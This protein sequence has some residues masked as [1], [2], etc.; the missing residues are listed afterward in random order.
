VRYGIYCICLIFV[1]S[2]GK[3]SIVDMCRWIIPT[4]DSEE[5]EEAAERARQMHVSACWVW[6]PVC[7]MK[8]TYS[9][10][11]K[12]RTWRG[13]FGHRREEIKRW[14]RVICMIFIDHQMSM[15]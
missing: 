11:A 13:I 12:N 1:Y 14:R 5:E 2:S 9:E 10:Q 4:T 15:R 8:G 3:V 7:H 6:I